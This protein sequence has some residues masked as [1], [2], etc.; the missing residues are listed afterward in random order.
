VGTRIPEAYDLYL[1]GRY[2]RGQNGPF[3]QAVEA[4]QGALHLDPGFADAHAQIARAITARAGVGAMPPSLAPRAREHTVQALRLDPELALAHA[5]SAA[6]SFFFDWDFAAADRSFRRALE[7]NPA[8]PDVHHDYAHFLTAIGR[9]ADAMDHSRR[10]LELNPL[11]ITAFAHMVWQNYSKGD[12]PSAVAAAQLAFHLDAK[13]GLAH[14]YLRTVYEEMGDYRKA[15]AEMA[16]HDFRSGLPPKV[17]AAYE[18][19]GPAGYWRVRYNDARSP[20]EDLPLFNLASY[21]ARLGR[22]DEAL[23]WI[24]KSIANRDAQMVYLA[25]DP[26]FK[27]LRTNPRFQELV[28]RVGL[29]N[30]T[31]R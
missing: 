28:R 1:R 29:P 12:L 15:A 3:N 31:A 7:L 21:S 19:D 6:I 4:F 26:A 24:E 25:I 20:A 18:K 17:L 23:Q 30:S 2:H 5:S 16:K 14:I 13:H 11:A 9:F 8:D 27:R 22:E 10:S